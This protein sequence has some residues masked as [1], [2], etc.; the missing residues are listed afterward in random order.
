[1]KNKYFILMS[2]ILF[3]FGLAQG[4]DTIVPKPGES[5]EF[6]ITVP[7]TSTVYGISRYKN[8]DFL[9]TNPMQLKMAGVHTQPLIVNSSF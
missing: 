7:E 3:A 6:Q 9:K 8:L 4:Q 5:R 2:L 1:M